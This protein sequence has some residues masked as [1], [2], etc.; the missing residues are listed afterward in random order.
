MATAPYDTQVSSEECQSAPN[1][2]AVSV[3]VSAAL[4]LIA[5]ITFPGVVR[6]FTCATFPTIKIH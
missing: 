3:N 4:N 5:F 1:V 2:V 6:T